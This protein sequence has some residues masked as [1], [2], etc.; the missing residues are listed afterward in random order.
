MSEPGG[1][2]V[3]PV[4]PYDRRDAG[5]TKLKPDSTNRTGYQSVIPRPTFP[6]GALPQQRRDPVAVDTTLDQPCG[7]HAYPG[8]SLSSSDFA[9]LSRLSSSHATS[10]ASA[11]RFTPASWIA[12]SGTIF[13][14]V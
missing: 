10:P 4:F 14:G 12:A 7:T 2:G 1:T 8:R 3:P 6:V 9:L 13:S 5:P 11:N